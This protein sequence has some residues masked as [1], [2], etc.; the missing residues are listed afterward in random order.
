MPY[1]FSP[2]IVDMLAGQRPYTQPPQLP[3]GEDKRQHDHLLG[4]NRAA[5]DLFKDGRNSLP[6]EAWLLP[7]RAAPVHLETTNG[8]DVAPE[9]YSSHMLQHGDCTIY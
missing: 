6:S 5:H 4:T 7:Q 3:L 9:A 1:I 2:M 8:M